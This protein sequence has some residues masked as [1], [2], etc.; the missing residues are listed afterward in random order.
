MASG[1]LALLEEAEFETAGE[2]VCR[3]VP[4]VRPDAKA[5]EVRRLLTMRR[6]DPDLL[7]HRGGGGLA[8]AAC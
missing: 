4:I 7:R 2:H 6:F 5:G 1:G 3:D 8:L